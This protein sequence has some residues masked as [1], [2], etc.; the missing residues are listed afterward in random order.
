MNKKEQSEIMNFPQALD[1]AVK[2]KFGIECQTSFDLLGSM[3]HTT[4][5]ETDDE[6]LKVNV[7]N[8]VEGWIAG[9]LE[10]RERLLALKK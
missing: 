10:L 6:V 8:F 1:A 3:K 7:N 2:E 4:Y 9:N 5:F